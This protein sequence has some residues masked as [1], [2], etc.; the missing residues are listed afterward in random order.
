MYGIKRNIKMKTQVKKSVNK[1]V[2]TANNRGH[3]VK[4]KGLGK[5]K[6]PI[7]DEVP[8]GNYFSKI[9]GIKT[10]TTRAGK[11]TLEV[12]YEIKDGIICYKIANGLLPQDAE[13]KPYFI[14]QSYPEDTQ[15][16][17][18]VI[19]ALSEALGV[20]T[21]EIG[22]AVGVTEYV[23]LSYDKS[24]I[25]GFSK[26]TPCDWEDFIEQN[27]SDDNTEEIDDYDYFDD[28]LPDDDD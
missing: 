16:Y 2:D 10:T 6:F 12:L 18:E 13:N 11:P 7:C 5:Y 9:T 21:F 17:D 25:G 14:K 20:D 4:S 23:A 8:S 19:D 24:V 3:I 28:F 15:Y 26:R 1:S 22:E 27:P